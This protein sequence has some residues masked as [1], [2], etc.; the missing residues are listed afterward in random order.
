MKK[1]KF[2]TYPTIHSEIYILEM[3][4]IDIKIVNNNNFSKYLSEPNEWYNFCIINL[5]IG[6]W[7]LVL[8]AI[9]TQI[10][11]WWFN[12]CSSK[13]DR[14]LFCK[15]VLVP[16]TVFGYLNL[17]RYHNIWRCSFWYFWNWK[18]SCHAGVFQY[19]TVCL[20][21]GFKELYVF[22]I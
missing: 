18:F 4:W 10:I 3:H 2:L 6:K 12:N 21:L 1:P 13:A 5:I 20:T 14:M 19:L 15:E 7:K 22:F 8:E 16:M 11:I 17:R 9:T